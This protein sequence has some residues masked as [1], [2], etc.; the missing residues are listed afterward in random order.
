MPPIPEV[1]LGDELF[2]AA[3]KFELLKSISRDTKPYNDNAIL[4]AMRLKSD[5]WGDCTPIASD[6][7][8]SAGLFPYLV[9]LE[10]G[11]KNRVAT[12]SF[13]SPSGR[14]KTLHRQQYEVLTKLLQGESVILSAPTS[15]GKTFILEE[16][17]LS[18]KYDNVMIVVPTIA[19]IEEIR[20]KV[21]DL[22][23]PH[24][25]IS[26]TGQEFAEKNIFVLTQERAHE[27]YPNIKR[28]LGEL[29]LLVIDEFYKMDKQL[30]SS[31]EQKRSDRSD[32]LSVVYREFSN[33]SKQVYLLGPHIESANGYDTTRHKPIWIHANGN[34][35]Y[36]EII[37]KK[38]TRTKPKSAICREILAEEEHDVMVYCSSPDVIRDLYTSELSSFEDKG[39]N[40]DLVS[41][42]SRN[43]TDEWYLI[44]A[45]KRGIGIHHGRLPRFIS[46]EM[47]RRFSDGRVDI[48]LCTSTVIEGVNTNAKSVI[49][50]N[51]K[52]AFNSGY[53]TFKNISGRAGRMFRHFS[54]KVYCFEIPPAN[55]DI[56][57]N[58]PIGSN[59][60]ENASLLNLLEDDNL[61]P[62]QKSDVEEHRSSTTL[63]T[64]L[65]KQ[66]LFI[67]IKVQE[68]V[69]EILDSNL[70]A[71]QG[72]NGPALTT[73]QVIGIF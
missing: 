72:I 54:G 53:L 20:K 48:L 4:V 10:I 68:D 34:T 29:D 21:K 31:E 70:S 25:R 56:V 27:L 2:A 58:D 17:L 1:L 24:K 22:N 38:A 49:I 5:E 35:T 32:L 41:W 11:F 63:P 60:T 61:S 57:V 13:K 36:L 46:Q 69:I 23:I 43:L 14:N 16:L 55:E 64:Y 73:N 8:R 3:D 37:Q 66:N 7:V 39:K 65:L 59:D 42:I 52:K 9:D 12:R 26:F 18:G 62:K 15:F 47:I 28:V 45:L 19:L 67:P 30:L 50:Y 40:S 44:E 33:S 6:I 71:F 51:N